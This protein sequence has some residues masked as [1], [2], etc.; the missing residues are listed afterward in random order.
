MP[1]ELITIYGRM[2]VL[3]ALQGDEVTVSAVFV[4]RNARGESFDAIVEA[5]SA[6]GVKVARVAPERLSRISGNSRHDQG[7]AAEVIAPGLQ[8]L[9]DWLLDAPAAFRLF[10]LDGIT[11]P[12]NVGMIIRTAVAAGF[13]GV[14]VP[15]AGVAEL[16]PLVI[17]ASAGVAFSATLLRSETAASAVAALRDAGVT[18]VGL[19]GDAATTIYDI[20][21]DDRQ[22]LVLGNE[23]D[24][25]R[26]E[27]DLSASIPLH[28]G[29][30]SLNVATAAAVTAFEMARRSGN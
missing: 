29:V 18:V 1:E 9:D 19:A 8:D 23:T 24:G 21:L 17:K 10:V 7:V 2:P 22:A 26:V 4:A 12:S 6:R 5:A 11:N 30:D 25:V 15:R 28:N 13:D 16:G 20:P 3:E 14:V 27:V